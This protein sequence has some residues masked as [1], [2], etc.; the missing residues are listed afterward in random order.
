MSPGLQRARAPFRV[1]NAITGLVLAGFVTGVWAYSISAVK[2]DDFSDIDEEAKAL[3]R[4]NPPVQ[5]AV[6]ADAGAGADVSGQSVDF[7]KAGFAP[8]VDPASIGARSG[9]G[10][11]VSSEGTRRGVLVKLLE[12]RERSGRMLDP[13]NKTLVWG[14]PPV[15]KLGRIGE[16]TLRK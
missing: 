3:A 11:G 4:V 10:V 15:D 7:V 14:A 5:A 9:Q 16:N 8:V 6:G 12:G 2:Q 1:R 13:T